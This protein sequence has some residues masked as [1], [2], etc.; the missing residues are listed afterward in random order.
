MKP[1]HNRKAIDAAIHLVF[2]MWIGDQISVWAMF[3]II[4]FGLWNYY[5][6]ATRPDLYSR[7]E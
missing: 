5:D 3:P 4:A 2:Y 7:D 1:I 6:G